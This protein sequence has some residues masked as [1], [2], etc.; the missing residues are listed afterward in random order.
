MYMYSCIAITPCISIIGAHLQTTTRADMEH[1]SRRCTLHKK[2]ASKNQAQLKKNKSQIDTLPETNIALKISL[3]KRKGGS[4]ASGVENK[5]L[6]N[7]NC[8]IYLLVGGF[9]EKKTCK[10]NI[11]QSSNWIMFTNFLGVNVLNKNS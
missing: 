6:G 1:N 5:H 3:A 11:A 4:I 9:S 8:F 7:C 10:K 2:T